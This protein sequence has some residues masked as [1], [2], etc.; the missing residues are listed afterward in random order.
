MLHVVTTALHIVL[1][2]KRQV[3][4]ELGP[5][6]IFI[7]ARLTAVENNEGHICV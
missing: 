4:A 5:F 1:S 3:V 7:T 2:Q 6:V